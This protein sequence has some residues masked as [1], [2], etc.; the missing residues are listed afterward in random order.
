MSDSR[1][2]IAIGCWAH[3]AAMA[4]PRTRGTG[5]AAQGRLRARS[6]THRQMHET[7]ALRTQERACEDPKAAVGKECDRAAEGKRARVE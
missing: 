5:G 1:V 2:G 4:L 7:G 3:G 6:P